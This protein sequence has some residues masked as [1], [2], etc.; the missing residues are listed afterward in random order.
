MEAYTRGRAEAAVDAVVILLANRGI[1]VPEAVREQLRAPADL[2]GARALVLRGLSAGS[3]EDLLEG[4][5]LV[6]G[7]I[8]G[9]ARAVV[10]ALEGRGIEVGQ[11]V[12]SRVLACIEYDIVRSWLLRI[13]TF[14]TAE[15]LLE[16][17][18]KGGAPGR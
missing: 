14:R 3:P 6:E 17:L 13:D 15:E 9:M 8:Q 12:R 1:E 2:E 4:P 18:P 5:N 11:A 10:L 16:D 7:R